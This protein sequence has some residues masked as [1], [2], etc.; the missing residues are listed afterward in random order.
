MTSVPASDETPPTEANDGDGR[1]SN[2][3]RN[4]L[5]GAVVSVLLGM[6]PF[7]PVLGGGVAGYL[8]GGD[9]RTGIRVGA[10]AGV[11]AAVPLTLFVIVGVVVAAFVPDGGVLGFLVL[12]LGVI[13]G[14]IA[15]TAVLS[16]VGGLVG[17]YARN[18][19]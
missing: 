3:L 13:V 8:E 19:L 14:V 2:T 1:M 10:I 5:I 7:S 15:Y 17:V 18:E 6:I 16:G 12:I 4:A 9:S 11:I